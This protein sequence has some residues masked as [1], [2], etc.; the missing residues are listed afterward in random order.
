VIL[1]QLLCGVKYSRIRDQLLDEGLVTSEQV[2]RCRKL[3]HNTHLTPSLTLFRLSQEFPVDF[4]GKELSLTAVT[5]AVY[6]LRSTGLF[7]SKHEG[8]KFWPW[9]GSGIAR[10]EASSLP[11]HAGRRMVNLRIVKIVEPVEC[12]VTGDT[13]RAVRPEEGE[14]VAI[15]LHRKTPIPWALD[16]DSE[17]NATA[18]LRALWDASQTV[19]LQ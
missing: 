12:T 17:V 18:A 4:G 5:D 14:L 19:L 15:R 6:P 2:I 3:F 9:T 16:I 7:A 13:G 8:R 11:E 10:F 1:P